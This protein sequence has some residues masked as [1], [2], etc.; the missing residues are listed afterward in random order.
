MVVHVTESEPWRV[1]ADSVKVMETKEQFELCLTFT[2]EIAI[3][4]LE[5]YNFTSIEERDCKLKPIHH[6]QG[7]LKES[8]HKHQKC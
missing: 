4:Q 6:Q 1:S 8:L 7:H 5:T 2:I 3:E